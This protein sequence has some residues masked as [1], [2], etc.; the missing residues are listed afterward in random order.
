M[1][2][3]AEVMQST[4]TAMDSA[5]L[6]HVYGT[7]RTTTAGPVPRLE[8]PGIEL[9][10]RQRT[11]SNRDTFNRL[12]HQVRGVCDTRRLPE[13]NDAIVRRLQQQ[14]DVDQ[15]EKLDLD[16]VVRGKLGSFL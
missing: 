6:L 13:F 16:A 12:C 3:A 7:S 4:H 14:I 2:S 15:V 9:G 8:F 5:L 1:I 11:N 10:L